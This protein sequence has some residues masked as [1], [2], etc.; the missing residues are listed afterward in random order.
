[1]QRKDK[2]PS[3]PMVDINLFVYNGIRTVGA[4]IESVL[5]QSWP[6]IALTLIDDGSTD[7]TF[8]LLRDYAARHPTIRVKWNR[9]NGGAIASFQRAFWFGDA[10]YVMPKSGDDVIAPDFV[11]RLMEVLLEHPNC[12]MAHAA[13]LIFR[14]TGDVQ[15]YY[16]PEHCLTAIGSP[17]ERSCKVMTAYTSSPSFWG[18][19]RRDAVDRLSPIRYRAGW[20]HVLL[21]ELALYGEIRH[22]PEQLYWRRDGGKPVLQLARAATAQAHTGLSFDD[23]LAEQRWRTPLITTAYAHMEM[24]ADSRLPGA[25]RLALMR[26][27]PAI[28]R[29]RWLPRMQHEAAA[30]QADLPAMLTRLRAAEPVQ[31][32]WMARSLIEAV[33]GV[34]A[35]IPEIDLTA[36]WFEIAALACDW[37][38]QAAR[39]IRSVS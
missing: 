2:M 37:P 23:P 22:V 19:Y 3:R 7:G 35:I 30:F 36:D 21:A 26:V 1:M 24:I 17:A 10:D 31:A 4:A 25:D 12:A 27:V 6:N 8:N 9:C 38:D 15:G 34:R 14:G 39:R 18:V 16:P 33:Q 20:D 32:G 5:A 11:E 29:A 13:G 28:F